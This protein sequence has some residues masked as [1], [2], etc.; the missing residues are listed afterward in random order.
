MDTQSQKDKKPVESRTGTV[1][2]GEEYSR[3]YGERVG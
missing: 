3:N 1:D 2:E